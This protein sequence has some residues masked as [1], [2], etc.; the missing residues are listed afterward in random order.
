MKKIT[1]TNWERFWL[2]AIVRS[3]TSPT[4]GQIRLGNKALDVLEMTDEEKTEVGWM[5]FPDRQQVGWQQE[6]D[7]ELEF[8]DDV[9]LIVQLYASPQHFEQW[10]Q[11]RRTEALYDKVVEEKD[12]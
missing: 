9:W 11:D 7:W 10:P 8:E 5:T 2:T 4:I 1:L 12:E 6:K 3:G